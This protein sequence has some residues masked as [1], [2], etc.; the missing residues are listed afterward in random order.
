MKTLV[1]MLLASASLAASAGA[2]SVLRA[3][4]VPALDEGALV[5]LALAVGGIAGW[6]VKRRG[7][8]W[9][10]GL[11][12]GGRAVVRQVGFPSTPGDDR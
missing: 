2:V 6:A 11:R 3:A 12:A 7:R 10:R 4:P 8:K 1:A 9:R 5:L